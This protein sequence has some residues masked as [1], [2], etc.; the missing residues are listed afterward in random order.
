M[1]L[2][3][4]IY[5]RIIG[6]RFGT[7]VALGTLDTDQFNLCTKIPFDS[8]VK[9]NNISLL[10]E[11]TGTIREII[12][13]LCIKSLCRF[14]KNN[15]TYLFCVFKVCVFSISFSFK[16]MT[17]LSTDTA[18][19]VGAWTWINWHLWLGFLEYKQF[20]CLFVCFAGRVYHDIIYKEHLYHSSRDTCEKLKV[21]SIWSDN[22]WLL[23]FWKLF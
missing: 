16:K 3:N 8:L 19:L 15:L 1:W 9:Q 23:T 6:N 18:S 14:V 21:R 20:V 13:L 11:F 5:L 10:K 22:E 12:T 7:I 4:Q 2:W 17:H